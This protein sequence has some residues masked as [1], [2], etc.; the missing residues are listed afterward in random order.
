MDASKKKFF[1]AREILVFDF[2]LFIGGRCHLLGNSLTPAA[3][4]LTAGRRFGRELEGERWM[5][6][7]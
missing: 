6:D 3:R 5:A 1:V 2:E 7:D 4:P